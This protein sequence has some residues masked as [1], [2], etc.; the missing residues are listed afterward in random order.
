V[1]YYCKG[2]PIDNR[3]QNTA[4]LGNLLLRECGYCWEND[5]A[6]QRIGEYYT[7]HGAADALGVSYW[8]L[9]RLVRSRQMPVIR[10]AGR[11]MLRLEEAR[12]ALK[13]NDAGKAVL[14]PSGRVVRIRE[15]SAWIISHETIN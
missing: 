9:Y 11:L 2:L 5:M 12:A 6:E 14:T 3:L 4:C 13:M 7:I 8:Q 1:F 10:L 15:V